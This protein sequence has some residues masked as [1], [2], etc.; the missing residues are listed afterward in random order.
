M[1]EKTGGTGGC[2]F[3][4]GQGFV[5]AA[6][7]QDNQ[8]LNMAGTADGQQPVGELRWKAPVDVVPDD[9]VYEAYY[10]SVK[11]VPLLYNSAKD[12]SHLY[13]W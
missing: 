13:M 4:T 2:L 12:I 6:A 8:N 9:G 5:S 1:S 3:T 11:D 10:N 7:V